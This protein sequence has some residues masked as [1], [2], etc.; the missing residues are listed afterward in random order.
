M[1]ISLAQRFEIL[2]RDGF[3]C[4]YCGKKTSE[5]E[6][7]VDHIRPRSKGGSDAPSNLTT[8]CRDCN[9]GKGDR[10]IEPPGTW[11]SLVGKFFH[12]FCTG[13]HIQQQGVILSEP[14]K[15]F[16][17]IQMFD[18]MS[19]YRSFTGT[20]LVRLEDIASERWSLYATGDEMRESHRYSGMAHTDA[21]C[22]CLDDS[23]RPPAVKEDD[24]EVE[25]IGGESEDRF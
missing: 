11:E 6:L 22:I 20:K 9:R 4:R 8:T 10:I 18:W 16:Y 21:F 23:P 15:G 3:K 2:E 12:T 14:A 1:T 5:T 19:G 7:E 24:L 17:V 13:G 25:L